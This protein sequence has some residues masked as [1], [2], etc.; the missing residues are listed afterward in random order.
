MKLSDRL[1]QLEAEKAQ[2]AAAKKPAARGAKGAAPAR[3]SVR[4]A[5]PQGIAWDGW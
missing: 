1:N 2:V 5:K 4:T 3:R